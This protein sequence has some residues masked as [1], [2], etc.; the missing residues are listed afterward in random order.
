MK[1]TA[2]GSMDRER[3]K[4]GLM[5]DLI[6]RKVRL[7]AYQLYEERGSWQLRPLT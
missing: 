4:H 1:I 5:L 2:E 3:V 7:R 6:E